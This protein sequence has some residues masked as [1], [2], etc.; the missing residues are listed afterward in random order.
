MSHGLKVVPSG[1]S[2]PATVDYH[3]VVQYREQ[4]AESPADDS[5][6]RSLATSRKKS[7]VGRMKKKP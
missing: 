5:V 7:L 4:G 1:V 2:E 6:N 3:D